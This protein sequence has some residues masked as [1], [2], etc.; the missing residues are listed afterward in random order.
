MIQR[1]D[2][3]IYIV[4]GC[5]YFGL[6]AVRVIKN[7]PSR[8]LVIAVD[9]DRERLK[10]V[11]ALADRVH[12]GDGVQYLSELEL[13]EPQ[14][15]LCWVVPALPLHLAGAW[16]LHVLNGAGGT[17]TAEKHSVPQ[18]FDPVGVLQHRTPGGTLFCSLGDF[19]CPEDCPEPEGYCH[20]TELSRPVPLYRILGETLCT[21]YRSLVVRSRLV[22]PGVGG[23][24][25]GDLLMLRA[26]LAIAG[27]SYLL[28]TACTCHGV[29]DAISIRMRG[30]RC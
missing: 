5:G 17:Y 11:T 10:A 19:T 26:A 27:G 3:D 12:H 15:A 7:L 14:A 9:K 29:T 21:G 8:P 28:S 22:L 2:R 6:R 1:N 18:E 4:I 16:L 25:F 24:L 23:Y 20:V 30:R 13:T